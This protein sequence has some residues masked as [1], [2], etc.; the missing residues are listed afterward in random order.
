MSK[1]IAHRG[2]SSR[3]PENTMLA[4]EK[5]IE[6]GCEGIE[7]DVHL[8]KD[9][10]IVIIHDEDIRRTTNGTGLV[11]DYTLE[12]LRKFD[13]SE[14]FA[15]QYGVNK[16]PILEE[17]FELI[18]G[19][20]MLTNI[21]LKTGIIKY[22]GIEEKVIQMIKHFKQEEHVIISSFN[23]YAIMSCK[24][25]E[26][27]IKCGFLVG[28]GMYNPGKYTSENGIEYIHPRYQMLEDEVLDEIKACGV[29]IN[30]WTVDSEDTMQM[31]IDKGVEGIITNYPDKLALIK[32][33][34]GK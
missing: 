16:I 27:K 7:F 17:Y 34:R 18:K 29:K 6:A 11:K 4:F 33:N 13:A 10:H 23:H 9:E 31:L 20:D 25:I 14:K 8:T 21:E 32:K 19:L 30:A 2:F 3:Y 15:G 28:D 12:D 1:N 5:A 26:P 22:K 24:A